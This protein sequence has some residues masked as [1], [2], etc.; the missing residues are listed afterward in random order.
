M[1]GELPPEGF[2]PARVES[3]ELKVTRTGYR[4]V[5]LR[6]R[7]AERYVDVWVNL[8]PSVRWRY[9]RQLEHLKVDTQLYFEWDGVDLTEHMAEALTFVL[10]ETECY[11]RVKHVRWQGLLRAQAEF[12]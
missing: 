6:M 11:V 4:Y 7:L 8:V 1:L 10:P 12:P 9:R 3:A 2:W 5:Q